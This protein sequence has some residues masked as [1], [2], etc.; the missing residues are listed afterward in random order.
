MRPLLPALALMAVAA[1][2]AAEERFYAYDP[3]SNS[4]QLMTRGITLQ[5]ERGLFGST[6]VERLF[7]TVGQGSAGLERGGLSDGQLRAV[8]PADAEE[9]SVYTVEAT[10]Q[11]AAL[12][13]ALCPGARAVWLVFGRVRP[14]RDLT[15]HAVGESVQGQITLCQT[16]HY[17][18]RGEWERPRGEDVEPGGNPPPL[19]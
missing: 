19:L 5:V 4:A 15:V 10:G 18:Y 1:P 7:A 13:R 11:G 2:A 17:R 14:L 12:G 3:A 9:T 6:R 8:L 16:L